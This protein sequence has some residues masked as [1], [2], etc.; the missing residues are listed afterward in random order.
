MLNTDFGGVKMEDGITHL[1][2]QFWGPVPATGGIEYVTHEW[3]TPSDA[4]VRRFTDW[5]KDTDVEVMLCVYNNDGSWNWDL[6]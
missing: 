1:A 2:L 3:Q 6:V 5:A 4:T